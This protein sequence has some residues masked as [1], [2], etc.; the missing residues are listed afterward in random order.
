MRTTWRP[1]NE[2]PLELTF[3]IRTSQSSNTTSTDIQMATVLYARVSTTDQA[4]GHQ[5]AHAEDALN[6]RCDQVV[7][8]DGVSGVHV[9]LKDRPEGRRLLDILRPADV[10]VVRWADRLPVRRPRQAQARVASIA[11]ACV[12]RY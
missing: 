12:A 7:C 1:T 5:Q 3:R 2:C 8:N 10:L 9:N 6:I 4:I 11:Q